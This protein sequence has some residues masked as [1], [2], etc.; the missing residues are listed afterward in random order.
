MGEPGRTV[1][2]VTLDE[3]VESHIWHSYLVLEYVEGGELFNYISKQDLL[4]EHEAVRIFRQIIAALSYCHQFNI[5]H[6]DLK[7]ENILMDGNRNVK[8]VDFGMAA[9]QPMN[10]WL[11]TPC[12]SPHYAAPEVI[13]AEPYRGDKADVW[14]CGVILFAMLTGFLPF[15]SGTDDWRDVVQVVLEGNYHIPEHLSAE[16]RDLIWRILQVDPRRRIPIEHMWSH[17]LLKKY[18]HLDALADGGHRYIGPPAPLTIKDCGPR[19]KQRTEIDRE[20][21]RNLRNLW[22]RVTEEEL[23]EKLLSDE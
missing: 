7:P 18:D 12:G 17:H 13:R 5:C 2:A 6:R 3:W 22:H 20:L 23:M 15:D 14:S 1:S 9:L 19:I 10:K 11:E 16:A 8:I 21:L 4:E